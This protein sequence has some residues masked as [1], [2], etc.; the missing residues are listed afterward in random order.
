MLVFDLVG[1]PF[2]FLSGETFKKSNVN[3]AFTFIIVKKFS[4]DLAARLEI[5]I[6]SDQNSTG[7]TGPDAGI[8][9]HTANTI[10]GDLIISARDFLEHLGL[11]FDIRCRSIGFRN[12][13]C[14]I[15]A[16]QCL[17]N[18]WR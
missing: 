17:K 8:E 3:P 11:A 5:R 10:R 6:A 18:H 2:H 13:K 15:A 16:C 12:I 9:N 1:S 14:Y 7:I 4:V